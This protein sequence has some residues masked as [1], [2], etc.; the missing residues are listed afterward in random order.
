MGWSSRHFAVVGG[1]RRC[2][3]AD[4]HVVSVPAGTLIERAMARADLAWPDLAVDVSV[5]DEVEI[6]VSSDATQPQPERD[7]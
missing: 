6:D 1:G 5:E 7:Q 2:D 3:R 4:E